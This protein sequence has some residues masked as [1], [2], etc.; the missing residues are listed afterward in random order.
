[1]SAPVATPEPAPAA[2][3]KLER[4]AAPAASVHEAP[5][6][7]LVAT[8]VLDPAAREA[9]LADFPK[10]AGAGFFPY[11]E[12]D[13]G[14]SIRALVAALN[15]AEVADALG[16]QLGL[17]GLGSHPTLVTLCRAL[18]SR[19]GNVH[20]DSLSKIATALVYLEP[21]W[22]HG[23]AGALRFVAKA[24][25]VDSLVVPEIPPVYGNFAIFRR[26]DNSFHGHLP[27][28]GQRRVIQVA[29]L[30]SEEEKLR[31]TRRGR[32]SRLIKRIAGA[33]DRRW[34]RR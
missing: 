24:D 1:M 19:H 7:F 8:G 25:D 20:T 3:L 16:A 14:P 27:F 18:N 23:S 5:F 12:A 28:E 17:P 13:C 30:T 32:F 9:L 31:K 34:R 29:W 4:L 11:E 21:E 6:R 26:A 2:P 10:Y 15:R 33:L 22:R